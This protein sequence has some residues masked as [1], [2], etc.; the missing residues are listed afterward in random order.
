MEQTVVL[1]QC[2]DCC[3]RLIKNE[4]EAVN[5]DSRRCFSGELLRTFSKGLEKAESSIG[6]VHET[7]Y[8]LKEQQL[9]EN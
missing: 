4:I 7:L 8:L 5:T 2:L 6:N 9:S 1:Q 3:E